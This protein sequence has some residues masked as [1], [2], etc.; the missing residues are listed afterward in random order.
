MNN[1]IPRDFKFPKKLLLLLILAYTMPSLIL[2]P[3]AMFIGAVTKEEYLIT[4]RDPFLDVFFLMQ[5]GFALASFFI[6][7]KKILSFDGTDKSAKDINQSTKVTEV[8]T[9]STPAILYFIEAFIITARCTARGANYVAFGD[10]TSLFAWIAILLGLTCTYSVLMDIFFIQQVEHI[11]SWLPYKKEYHTLTL[12]QRVVIISLIGITGVVLLVESVF[13][14]PVNHNVERMTQLL[15]TRL[16]PISVIAGLMVVIDIY[17]NM[18][19]IKKNLNMIEDFTNELSNKNYNINPL[20]I[21]CRYELGNLILNINSFFSTT[22][23]LLN[24]FNSNVENS[25]STADSLATN[26]N[27]ASGS[28]SAITANINT[29][30][31][32]MANQASGVEEATASVQQIIG[33]LRDLNSSIETQATAVNESS[34]AVDEMVANIRSVT[35]ILDKNAGAVN[36]LGQASD[37]GRKTVE[38]AVSTSENIMNQSASL[39]E[40]SQVIQ[41]IADQ[42][43]LLA[44][45]AA[46]EAAHAGE[47]G[48]GFSVVADEIRKLAE[49]SNLQGKTINESL[50]TLSD[51]ISQVSESTKQVQQK[52]ESIYTLAQ[53]VKDQETVIMNAMAEQTSGNQQVLD[54][55]KDINDSTEN[56]K[57]GSA[58]MLSGGEQA[59]K[60]MNILSDVTRKINDRMSEMTQ[61]VEQITTAMNEVNESSTK[62]QN[63]IQA[64]GGI[65]SVFKL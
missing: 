18:L 47:S 5:I 59:V 20:P 12:M 44:M 50:K 15:L 10:K 52:F 9:I 61:S 1:A 22:K 14:I 4:I 28:V 6:L 29:V 39:L 64:L 30:H 65:I 7:E 17:M 58:E 42:T 3:F 26:M 38:K 23:E 43:N 25:V 32:E 21:K 48:K 8:L 2:G 62:N 37:E 11:L 40:A 13:M 33:K 57:S 35:S 55:M 60:E 41:N 49:Q 51:A 45:N 36:S 31:N 34:A 27:K 16:L 46:I 56:V 19:D 53:T 54:A 63:D 24:G